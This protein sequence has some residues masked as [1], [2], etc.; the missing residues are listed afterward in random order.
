MISASL[1]PVISCSNNNIEYIFSLLCQ[2]NM[3]R[4]SYK[5]PLILNF[6]HVIEFLYNACCLK[7]AECW[8]DNQ[9]RNGGS[10]SVILQLE[11]YEGSAVKS[12]SNTVTTYHW[13]KK[14][15]QVIQLITFRCCKSHSKCQCMMSLQFK[16]MSPHYLL[17]ELEFPFYLTEIKC[18]LKC[19][20]F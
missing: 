2:Y 8:W 13:Q 17:S 12:T 11:R 14:Q 15:M 10:G 18:C 20:C 7:A 4:D 3:T 6:G 16:R 5:T 1:K 19:E 9:Q